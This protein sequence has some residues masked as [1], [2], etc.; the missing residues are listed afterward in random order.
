MLDHEKLLE[1]LEKGDSMMVKNILMDFLKY[2]LIENSSLPEVQRLLFYKHVLKS[3][4]NMQ[5]DAFAK[6]IDGSKRYLL[7]KRGIYEIEE[8]LRKL[9]DIIHDS[10]LQQK[11]GYDMQLK[12][13]IVA[14]IERNFADPEMSLAKLAENFRMSPPQMSRFFKE[15]MGVNYID[16]ISMLRIKAAKELL[17]KD[18]EKS[19]EE[20]GRQVGYNNVLTFRRAFKKFEYVTPGQYK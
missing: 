17:S 9:C 7:D 18:S 16:Y 13:D 14:Y 6:L 15:K 2:E 10:T 19:I 4:K 5:E 3:I 20:I 8:I 1:N 11:E 12:K